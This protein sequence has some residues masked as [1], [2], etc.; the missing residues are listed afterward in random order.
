MPSTKKELK[1]ELKMEP[2]NEDETPEMQPK[3]VVSE[4][5]GQMSDSDMSSIVAALQNINDSI[6]N[7]DARL[8]NL[9]GGSEMEQEMTEDLTGV[10]EKPLGDKKEPVKPQDNEKGDIP[11]AGA[12]IA[13][14]IPQGQV[15]T[16]TG[17]APGN[18]MDPKNNNEGDTLGADNKVPKPSSD[19]SKPTVTKNQMEEEEEEDE[20]E[21]E[22]MDSEDPSKPKPG[23]A[24]PKQP[25]PMKTGE[26]LIDQEL[27]RLKEELR[28]AEKR[29]FEAENK[30]IE[31]F[32]TFEGM[33][34]RQSM[35][36]SVRA[37]R[38]RKE[39]S[40]EQKEYLE[41]KNVVGSIIKEY[42][43]KP[44]VADLATKRMFGI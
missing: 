21:K 3:G 31:Q 35:I 13:N 9:E 25:E 34:K 15:Q 6:A 19:Y 42:L 14:P 1:M 27:K 26:S 33:D 43:N 12:P 39:M 11:V 10:P 29:A 20:N 8:T 28:L 37:E 7:I 5:E 2:V 23:L 22:S 16:T 44:G 18:A 30:K 17:N 4:Q 41:N 36:G 24:A 40:P 32:N 38:T